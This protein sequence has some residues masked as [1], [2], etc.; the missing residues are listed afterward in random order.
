[1]ISARG[2]LTV[3]HCLVDVTSAQVILGA[4]EFTHIEPTQQRFTVQSSNFRVHPSYNAATFDNDIAIILLPGQG[5]TL[6]QFVQPVA[7]P[8]IGVSD[9]FVGE[10]ATVSG[11]GSFNPG[12]EQGSTLL[13]SAENNII[14]NAA[15]RTSLPASII[16]DSSIC[17]TTVGNRGPCGSMI[18]R[19]EVNLS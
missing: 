4:H 18:Q 13:R 16:Q 10:L 12:S 17:I 1:L 6:N 7:L 11:W 8:T 5:A 15:C 9:L 3:A 2:V 14:T 19:S